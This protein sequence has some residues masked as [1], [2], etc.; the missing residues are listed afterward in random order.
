MRPDNQKEETRARGERARERR[1]KEKEKEKQPE[2]EGERGEGGGGGGEE[3]GSRILEENREIS[4]EEREEEEVWIVYL[5]LLFDLVVR[6]CFFLPIG[7]LC[8]HQRRVLG[9]M[10]A[11]GVGASRG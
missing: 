5:F 6:S 7:V 9:S 2:R 10:V 11:C 8:S 3:R 4:E 1:E